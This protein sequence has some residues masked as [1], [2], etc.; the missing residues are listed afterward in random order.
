[1]ELRRPHLNEEG[2]VRL[3]A[4]KALDLCDQIDEGED[5]TE[6]RTPVRQTLQALSHDRR[7]MVLGGAGAGK[8]TLLSCMA[9][10]QTI[11]QHTTANHYTCWRFICRDGDASHSRFIPLPQLE[12]LELVDTADITREEVRHTCELLMQGADVVVGVLDARAPATSPVWDV[13]DTV[14]ENARKAWMLAVAQVN[15]LDARESIA[16]KERLRELSRA[17]GI[18]GMRILIFPEPGNEAAIVT[19]R[20]CVQEILEDTHGAATQIRRLAE[21]TTDLVQRAGRILSARES[22]SRTYNVF[23]SGIEQEIDNFLHSQTIGLAQYSHGLQLTVQQTLPE[24]LAQVRQKLGFI[25]SPGTLLRMELMGRMTEQLLYQCMDR[26][27]QRMQEESDNHFVMQCAAHWQSVRPRMKKALECEIG[28]FPA[29][30]LKTELKTLRERLCRQ[31]YEPMADAG[32]QARLFSVYVAHVSWMQTCVIC[33]CIFCVLAGVLGC[34]GQDALGLGCVVLAVL[35]WSGGSIAHHVASRN[36]GTQIESLVQDVF[37][38]Q[39]KDFLSV[40]EALIVSRVTA[41]RQ[42]YVVPRRKVAKREVELRPL[43][44]QQ[45]A[46]HTQLRLLMTHL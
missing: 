8:S 19:L 12:G 36:I 29:D 13:L 1:M 10:T 33:E 34:L 17:H 22:V 44:E 31:L 9:G 24:L 18:D 5:L 40:L 37:S 11:A 26:A 4:E 45:R 43:Q 15:Q 14:P 42:L 20:S 2:L 39:E 27:V 28:D 16:L 6:Y 46:I 35:T 25:L 7:I 30:T 41:Y 21:L 3:W 38:N 23:M 32:L